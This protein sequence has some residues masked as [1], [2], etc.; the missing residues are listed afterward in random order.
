MT[1]NCWMTAAAATEGV[2]W[3]KEPTDWRW[4]EH[5]NVTDGL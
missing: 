2:S 5:W 1:R 3:L 4:Q